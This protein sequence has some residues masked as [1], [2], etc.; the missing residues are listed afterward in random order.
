MT[1]PDTTLIHSL[2]KMQICLISEDADISDAVSL[3]SHTVPDNI[4]YTY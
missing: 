4:K 1:L 3:K 2:H